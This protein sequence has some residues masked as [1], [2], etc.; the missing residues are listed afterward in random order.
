[1]SLPQRALAGLP[2]GRIVA[3]RGAHG[4]DSPFSDDRLTIGCTFCGGADDTID[5]TPSRVFLDP[6][7]PENLPV[8]AACN[9]CNQS[10]SKDEQYVA[11][12]IECA[13]LGETDPDCLEREK[14][15]RILRDTPGLAARL[16]SSRR[17]IAEQLSFDFTQRSV[18]GDHVFEVETN[19][20][21]SVVR[22][23]GMGHARYETSQQHIGRVAHVAFAPLVVLSGSAREA[24]EDDPTGSSVASWPEIGSRAFQRIV[25]SGDKAYGGAWIEI[26]EGRYR[27]VV[28]PE[29]TVVRMVFSEYLAAEVVWRHD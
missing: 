11:C 14:I 17:M 9:T 23:L 7:Y 28:S 10:F 8:V 3:L 26:Q 4:P 24:F 19:R 6:P 2:G 1:M 18:R 22:K 27:Y 13:R 29:G 21:E 16:T 25:V 15:R 5:H 12:L 20:V